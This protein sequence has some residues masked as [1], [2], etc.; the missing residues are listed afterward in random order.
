MPCRWPADATKTRSDSTR[1]KFPK[2][3]SDPRL[4]RYGSEEQKSSSE[5]RED[6]SQNGQQPKHQNSNIRANASF[7][8]SG[9]DYTFSDSRYYDRQTGEP[10]SVQFERV[11]QTIESSSELETS[12]PF[13]QPIEL[14]GDAK[15]EK[16]R[17]SSGESTNSGNR[18]S[19]PENGTSNAILSPD[20]QSASQLPTPTLSRQVSDDAFL[21][22]ILKDLSKNGKN[23][24]SD[25][26]DSE[27]FDEVGASDFLNWWQGP[28]KE[29][30]S[31][32]TY[33]GGQS[34]TVEFQGNAGQ[35][36]SKFENQQTKL[37]DLSSSC[38]ENSKL[39]CMR[40]QT[41]G[42]VGARV[43]SE[44]KYFGPSSETSYASGSK[45]TQVAI[46][47]NSQC[48]YMPQTPQHYHS[49]AT[50]S[51]NVTSGISGSTQP[52]TNQR[53]IGRCSPII[54]KNSHYQTQE[55]PHIFHSEKLKNSSSFPSIHPLSP[56]K[57]EKYS[58]TLPQNFPSS[59]QS[60]PNQKS[61]PN[62]AKK[63]VQVVQ[64]VQSTCGQAYFV[65]QN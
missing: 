5:E 25:H 55:N 58:T 62:Q 38:F 33:P 20:Y 23:G 24:S 16:S 21:D 51:F 8:H 4:Q 15:S 46:V 52:A 35:S 44:N 31:R 37:T 6:F 41:G 9:D 60:D 47:D 43:S 45:K 7:V 28:A 12:P 18:Q 64:L 56:V 49:S 26:I 50:T 61:P 17:N 57:H 29:Q 19:F 63:S 30:D 13:G 32:G 48:Q 34:N 59:N 36:D 65:V 1:E 40:V 3:G 39:P 11:E 27:F 42:D 53:P 10:E 22:D 14:L 54:N 2:Y